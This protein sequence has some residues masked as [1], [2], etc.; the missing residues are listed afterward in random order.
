[1]SAE[2]PLFAVYGASGVAGSSLSRALVAAGARVRWVGRSRE[3]LA[4]AMASCPGAPP[5]ELALAAADDGAA[6]RA[7]F[8][9][10]AV[11]INAA[12]P[13]AEVGDEVLAAAIAA[14]CHY[15]DLC[16]EQAVLR[17]VFEAFDA[18]A[19]HAEVAVVPGAGLACALGDLLAAAAAA[20]LLGHEDEGPVV[21][22]TAGARLASAPP[23]ALSIGYLFDD[24]AL[25]AGAQASVFANLGAPMVVWRR[26][27][28]DPERPGRRTRAFN[29]GPP[30]AASELAPERASGADPRSAQ[31]PPAPALPPPPPTSTERDAFSLGGGDT[32]T[33]PRHV[34]AASIDTYLSLSR[35][36]PVQGALR[37]AALAASWLPASASR[38]L[39][40]T[41]IDPA[42][43][44]ATR[45]AVIATAEHPFESCHAVA[46]G[47]DL[48][49]TSTVI[50]CRIALALARRAQG[51]TGV[52]AP[53]ELLR[54]PAFLAELAAD[55]V[56]ALR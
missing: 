42:A 24:L 1:M 51:P 56:L 46:H 28:W 9:G 39:V 45:F 27:R 4:Q 54:A 21:R 12:G 14:G 2:P 41:P 31:T 26:D 50:T 34:A 3:R 40:P 18:A 5:Q 55:H 15:L 44:A 32:I 13:F 11:V 8:D 43:L 7:A 17:H 53:A 52:R 29:P 33:V 38:L 35:K 30:P 49:T 47:R 16:A 20:R 23:L 37:L 25:P 10:A 36:A 48:Y 22:S 19:R 6:L